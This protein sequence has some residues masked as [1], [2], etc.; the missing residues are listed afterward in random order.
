LEEEQMA[1]PTVTLHA[2][3]N[4]IQ[5][6]DYTPGSAVAAGDVVVQGDMVGIATQDIAANALGALAVNNGVWTCPKDTGSG[7]ALSAGTKVYWDATNEVV[8]STASTHKQMGYVETAAA[9]SASTVNVVK[10]PP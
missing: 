2:G 6:A 5:P 8:T 4:E 1:T 10:V 7:S 9:A 3:L